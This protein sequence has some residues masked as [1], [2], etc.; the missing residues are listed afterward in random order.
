MSTR[1]LA[2]ECKSQ[3]LPPS[4]SDLGLFM[5][6]FGYDLIIKKAK[7]APTEVHGAKVGWWYRL[8]DDSTDKVRLLYKNDPE[9]E[10]RCI[11]CNGSIR[12]GWVWDCYFVVMDLINLK[13]SSPVCIECCPDLS[14]I[15][16]HFSKDKTY[17]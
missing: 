13:L 15:L 6:L 14:T 16:K 9:N 2:R 8:P 17:A 4:S 7:K 10:L 5:R 11:K 1:W 3:K 12:E